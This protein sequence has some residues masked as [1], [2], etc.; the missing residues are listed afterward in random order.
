M[1]SFPS[2]PSI[3]GCEEI[4]VVWFCYVNL[5]NSYLLSP[6]TLLSLYCVLNKC[7]QLL[8]LLF[9]ETALTQQTKTVISVF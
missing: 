7:L 5:L 2:I 1:S 4:D 3:K 9:L 8:H 6:F